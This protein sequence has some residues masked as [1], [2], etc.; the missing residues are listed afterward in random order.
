YKINEQINYFASYS[1][2]YVPVAANFVVNHKDY[3]SDTPFKAERSFQVETGAKAG[4]LNNQL[5][6]D[7]SLFRIERQNMLIGTGR[8]SDA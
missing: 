7:L 5:Q 6:M 2:G 3:G 8:V 4:F 1:Q